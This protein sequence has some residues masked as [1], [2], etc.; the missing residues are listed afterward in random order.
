MEDFSNDAYYLFFSTLA[1]RTRLA[2]IDILKDGSKNTAEISAALNQSEDVVTANL[3]PMLEC[4]II[5][6]ETSG[7]ERVYSLNKSI[8][9]PISEA[10]EFHTT[11]HCPGLRACISREKLREYIKKEAAKDTF[12]DH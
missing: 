3:K 11:K 2:I 6:P 12:I 10:L 8:I 9:A 7:S 4:A 5:I 1:S